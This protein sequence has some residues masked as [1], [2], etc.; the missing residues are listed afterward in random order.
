MVKIWYIKPIYKRTKSE[1]KKNVGGGIIAEKLHL[2]LNNHISTGF[3]IVYTL[4]DG[5][6][7][8]LQLNFTF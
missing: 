7:H 3:N 2:V 4:V 8:P 1:K 6:G 5:T